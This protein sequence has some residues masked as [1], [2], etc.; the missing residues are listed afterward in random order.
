MTVSDGIATNP[1]TELFDVF[2]QYFQ[3]YILA[4]FCKPGWGRPVASSTPK[5]R[6]LLN[7]TPFNP[8]QKPHFWRILWLKVN[9][10]GG[11]WLRT[12][13]GVAMVKFFPSSVVL[14]G[15]G[16]FIHIFWQSKD[17]NTLSNS[18]SKTINF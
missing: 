1:V 6:T 9:L 17:Y 8:P 10:L 4:R 16:P 11:S 7:L 18:L 14:D 12:W 15:P 2:G 13:P 3:S 5:K